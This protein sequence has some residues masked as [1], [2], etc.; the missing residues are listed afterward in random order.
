MIRQYFKLSDI[1]PIHQKLDKPSNSITPIKI[2]SD[3]REFENMLESRKKGGDG[4][5]TCL[6]VDYDI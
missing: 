2:K 4:N 5:P 1:K 3:I 6:I